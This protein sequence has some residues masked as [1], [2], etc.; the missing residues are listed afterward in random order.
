[1][2]TDEVLVCKTFSFD[3]SHQLIGHFGKCANVH[4]HTYKLE[5]K[6]KDIPTVY[7]SPSEVCEDTSLNTQQ[8]M[9]Q[10]NESRSNEGFVIDFYHLK[11]IVND[12]IV[13]PMDHAF[14]AKGDEPILPVLKAEGTK[15]VVLGFR[16]TVENMCRYICWKL[17]LAGLP[18][19]SV[20]MWETPTGW[21]E[22]LADDIDTIQGPNYRTMGCGC[23]LDD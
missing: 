14:L 20:R 18:V 13:E 15:V 21:A 23:D 6:V 22:V 10:S 8:V 2:A 3:S 9:Y 19:H 12:L 7:R 1:M 5:V 4:G 16:T 17:L 11:T